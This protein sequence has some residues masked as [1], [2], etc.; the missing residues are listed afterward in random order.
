MA[1]SLFVAALFLI[2]AVELAMVWMVDSAEG[3]TVDIAA[4]RAMLALETALSQMVG[5]RS[6][7][8]FIVVSAT[9]AKRSGLFP[10][11]FVAVSFA[12][13]VVLLLAATRFE[14]VAMLMPI[15][16]A[17]SSVL[18]L[19]RRRMRTSM[20]ARR[21]PRSA[22]YT[23]TRIVRIEGAPVWPRRSD[24]GILAT[25]FDGQPVRRHAVRT[26]GGGE[27]LGGLE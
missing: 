27:E 7:A 23:S 2:A 6:A 24:R 12:V 10:R 15:W 3:E 25:G 14:G 18:V 21:P 8:V 13:A 22:S 16:V 20:R 4:A 26:G 9:R 17:A 11:W 19:L 5:L 1:G